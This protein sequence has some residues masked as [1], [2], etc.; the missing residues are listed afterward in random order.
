MIN[1]WRKIDASKDKDVY[2][3]FYIQLIDSLMYLVNTSIDICFAVN[4]LNQFMVGPKRV[5]WKTVRNILRSLCGTFEY[6]LRYTRGDGVGI[7]GYTNVK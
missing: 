6:G 5:H 1:N 7:C 3:T 4:T 2:L